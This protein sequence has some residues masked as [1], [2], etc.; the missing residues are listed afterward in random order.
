MKLRISSEAE[1]DLDDIYNFIARDSVHYARLFVRELRTSLKRL[2]QFPRSGRQ[3]ADQNDPDVRETYFKN[4][5]IAYLITEG[6]IDI[7]SI[8][9]MARHHGSNGKL[10]ED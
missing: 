7:A 3:I 10:E 9:H 8:Q 5:R 6:F 1:S 4:Y 2:L